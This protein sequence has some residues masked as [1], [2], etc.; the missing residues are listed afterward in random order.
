[1]NQ[2]RLHAADL[3]RI[4]EQMPA[5]TRVAYLNAGSLGP[6]PRVAADAM[7]VQ[8]QYDLEQRQSAGHWD[9]LLELQAQARQALTTLV[10][11][12]VEQVAL[13]H[14][15]HEGLN[16]CLWGLDLAAGDNVVTTDE[17]H[18]GML[19]PLQHARA[20]SGCEVRVARWTDD[21]AS[22]VDAMLAKVDER[23]RAIFLSHVSWQSGRTAP[24]RMLRDAL[25]PSTRL[26]VDGAQ[27]AGMLR[28]HPA[29]GWDAYTVS[30]Q[31]WPCGPNGSGGLALVD[32]LAWKPT[33][34]AYAQM[35]SIGDYMSSKL[36]DDGRRF[37]M[38]QESLQPVA[39]LAASVGW[40]VAEV[41][42]PRAH[43]HGKR[44][45][46]LARERLLA[47]GISPS[48]LHGVEH[49]LS[50]DTPGNGMELTTALFDS[51]YLIRALDPDRIRLSFGCW[52]TPDEVLACVDELLGRLRG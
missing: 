36:A 7:R 21:D 15:T 26:V 24:L 11:V 31:K 30:G 47:A 17:E 1:M 45:N 29:D 27:S 39:G 34:G 8:D 23:T 32:P 42:L 6:L 2:A 14:S 48:D 4:R 43:A 41:G 10:A 12:S 9:R 33:Y 51:G 40:L 5:T 25:P 19:V 35:A 44:L 22:F 52:N 50:I 49:L 38:S 46:A 13:M 37:E 28:V 20:R 3:A 16:V 18:P